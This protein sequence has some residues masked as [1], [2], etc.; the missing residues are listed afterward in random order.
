MLLGCNVNKALLGQ[1]ENIMS[2]GYVYRDCFVCGAKE[3]VLDLADTQP[4]LRSSTCSQCGYCEEH[5]EETS[6]I[7]FR[8]GSDEPLNPEMFRRVAD[9]MDKERARKGKMQ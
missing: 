8:C 3:A 7:G 5:G 4:P 6:Y 9:L 2:T 1:K